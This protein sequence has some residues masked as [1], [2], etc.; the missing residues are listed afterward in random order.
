VYHTSGKE[1]PNGLIGVVHAMNIDVGGVEVKVPVFVIEDCVQDLLLGR[2]WER[3]VRASIINEDDGSVTVRIHSEDGRR[4]VRFTGI[5]A[6]HE[7]NCEYAKHP[8]N[9]H[10][11]IDP[12]KV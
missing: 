2:P 7:R 4:A 10:I 9:P 5:A 8:S 12:L 6:N 11:S 3:A 1:P